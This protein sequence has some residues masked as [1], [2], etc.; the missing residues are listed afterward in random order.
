MASCA[1]QAI[2]SSRG[3]GDLAS[4]E[5]R[6]PITVRPPVLMTDD[7]CKRHCHDPDFDLNLVTRLIELMGVRARFSLTFAL[8]KRF[9]ATAV[10][11]QRAVKQ[12]LKCLRLLHLCR[13]SNEEIEVVVA[14]ASKYLRDVLW[15][16][17][18]SG[19]PTM[20]IGELAYTFCLL[21]F[22]A[23][24]HILDETC[25]LLVWHK[26]LFAKYCSMKVLNAAVIRL[27]ERLSFVLR[28]EPQ[29]LKDKL[30]ALGGWRCPDADMFADGFDF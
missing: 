14:H 9:D 18:S 7:E 22:I 12:M 3:H 13:Y 23:H 27:L 21:I 29:E 6:P 20:D 11:V 17:E 10:E 1:V 26:H 4:A 15:D 16:M 2:W 8:A 28:V 24:S 5:G 25:P 19:A 30:Q